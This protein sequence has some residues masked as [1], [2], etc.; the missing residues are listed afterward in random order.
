MLLTFQQYRRFLS[1]YLWPQ[2]PRVVLL[3]LLLFATVG[4]QLANPQVVR[5][6]ID[7][8]LARSPVPVLLGSGGVFL[9]VGLVQQL[10]ALAVVWVGENV[11]WTATNQL[12][13]DLARHCLQLEM[14][15]HHERT[16][17]ELIERID[18]DTTALSN[19]FSQFLLRV[20]GAALLLAGT[21]ATVW[22]ENWQAGL[23]LV[24]FAALGV[25][26]LSRVRHVAVAAIRAERQASAGLFGFLEERLVGLDDIRANG[27]GPHVLRRYWQVMATLYKEGRR[28]WT[29][30]A[31]L[32]LVTIAI[33]ALGGVLACA[34][35][36]WLYAVGAISLGTAYLFYQYTELVQS[37]LEQLT[38]ELSNLQKATASLGRIV[39]LLAIRSQP[40]PEHEALCLEAGAL[41]VR[42]ERVNFAYAQGKPV[43]FD[44]SFELP[45]GQVLGLLGRTGSGKTSLTRLLLR[46]WQPQ[47]GTICLGGTD[48]WA[49]H[50][51]QLRERV[52][53]VTQDVQ[54][55]RA[56]VRDNLTFFDRQIPDDRLIAALEQV[57]LANWLGSLECGLDTE[58]MAAGKGLSAGEAQLLAFAR[59]LLKDPGL[60]ILDEPSSRLDPATEQRVE[61]AIRQLMAGRT[62]III[63][64]RLSTVRRVD[65]ILILDGGRIVEQGER[66]A[67]AAD[68]RSRFARL[69]AND[70][71]EILT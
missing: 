69:L 63:A 70:L 65:R 2:W 68:R 39:E 11:G 14:A 23:A 55:F 64:H 29:G 44:L 54:L 1:L 50:R 12:R 20:M 5:F 21:I 66:A 57:D 17:G 33:F 6:F 28:A 60:V 36:A 38:T 47:S 7:A 59:V 34:V 58:L 32:W 67:L 30:R 24:L 51:S 35:G 4:L 41:A 53:V 25:Y 61:R 52:G 71:S 42:F 9:A 62:G 43:L 8:A 10:C 49:V 46:L 56:S 27:A 22:I 45:A 40:E 3:A 18:G 16:P 19:F 31:L 15:F 37:P 48:L 26:A 13:A